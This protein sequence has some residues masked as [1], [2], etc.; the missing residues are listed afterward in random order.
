[1]WTIIRFTLSGADETRYRTAF[2]LLRRAGF[3]EHHVADSPRRCAA[4]PA[5]V[6]GD[7]LQDP[8]VVART[9]FE[10]FAEARLS[11]VMVSGSHV[12]PSRRPSPGA[13]LASG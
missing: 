7:V 8:S 6:V 9:I 3:R 2:E 10:T 5:A 1:M 11:P 13:P 12:R 4:F